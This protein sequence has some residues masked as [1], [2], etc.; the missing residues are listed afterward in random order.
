MSQIN[1]DIRQRA[2]KI[3]DLPDDGSGR[4]LSK[5]RGS[6]VRRLTPYRCVGDEAERRCQSAELKV[7]RRSNLS[8]DHSDMPSES[9]KRSTCAGGPVARD[10]K[11]KT[12]GARLVTARRTARS[13]VRATN[14]D[15]EPVGVSF[16]SVQQEMCQ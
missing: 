16:S 4:Q 1:S 12:D 8:S 6:R 5:S 9:T 10:D 3:G 11:I 2:D 7:I 13:I 14:P 15:E